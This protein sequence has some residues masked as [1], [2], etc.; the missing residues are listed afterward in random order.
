MPADYPYVY[1]HS[2]VDARRAKETR[3]YEDS[4]RLNV[5]C[6]CAIEQAVRAHFDESNEELKDG[7]AQV[8]LEQYGFMRVNFVLA[9]S[10]KRM[11]HPEQVGK[12]LRQWALQRAYVPMD[13]SNNHDYAVNASPSLL[14]AFIEQVRQAYQALGLFGPEHCVGKCQELDFTGKVMVL[15]P[16]TLKESCWDPRNQLWLAEGGFGCSPTSMGRAVYAACLGDGERTRWDR[17]D[18]IGVLDERF[19]PGWAAEKLTELRGPQEKQPEESS[20]GMEMK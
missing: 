8:V 3:Q 2:R 13:G 1:P 14:G 5:S 16:D 17:S 4:F 7:C 11:D 9:N 19:L 18:F 10:I 6:S 12:E 20:G 15:S